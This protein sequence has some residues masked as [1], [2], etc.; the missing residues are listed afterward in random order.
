MREAAQANEDA[1]RIRTNPGI[2]PINAAGFLAYAPELI[3]FE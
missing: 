3:E 2:G 1:M